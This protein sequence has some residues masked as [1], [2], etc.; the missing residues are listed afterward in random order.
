M[1]YPRGATG[2]AR[3]SARSPQAW[4]ICDRDGQRY[5]RSELT[6]QYEWQGRQLTNLHILVCRRCY[7]VPQPQLY[8]Y[9]PPPDPV[10]VYQARPDLFPTAGNM[11]FTPYNLF[12]MLAQ[13]GGSPG[14][15]PF[16]PWPTTK[17]NALAAL[18]AQSGVAQPLGVFDWSQTPAANVVITILPANPNRSWVAIYSPGGFFVF[19]TGT[20]LIGS[21]TSTFIDPGEAWFWATAQG[22]GA[23]WNGAITAISLKAG[24]PLWA[25]DSTGA[26]FVYD[27]FGNPVI[28]PNGLPVYAP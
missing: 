2:H 12:N 19:S 6:E 8:Q 9:A 21:Q 14:F 15:S 27:P 3:V 1:A 17:A 11:G 18:A 7:D 10:P 13:P 23:P 25:W 20:A 5:L 16:T 28:G 4:G 26:D 24:S 22:K